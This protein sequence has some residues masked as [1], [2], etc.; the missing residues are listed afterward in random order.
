MFKKPMQEDGD[1]DRPIS[2]EAQTVQGE[3]CLILN[4]VYD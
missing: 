1:A 3:V 2:E 4:T